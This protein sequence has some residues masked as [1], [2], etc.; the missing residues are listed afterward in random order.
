MKNTKSSKLLESFTSYCEDNPEQ[1]FF[2]ALRNWIGCESLLTW[3]RKKE[4]F[5][6]DYCMLSPA[7][8]ELGCEDTFYW[9][10]KNK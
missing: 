1:R 3:N 7:L 8:E 2:Q 10:D 5:N 6:G 4:G 9:Q